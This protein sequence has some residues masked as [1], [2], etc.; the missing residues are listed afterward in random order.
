MPD[1][2][3]LER[4]PSLY[5][6]G[7]LPYSTQHDDHSTDLV[8]WPGLPRM[9]SGELWLTAVASAEPASAPFEYGAL[10][11]ANVIIYDRALAPVV[12]KFLPLGGYAEPAAASEDGVDATSARCVRFA[13]DGWSVV[14]LVQP[15]SEF[16]R[17]SELALSL[18][19]PADLRVPVFGNLGGGVYE[20][21]EIRLEEI[22]YFHRSS[23]LTVICN[24]IG[25][26][27]EPH[28][29][30]ASTNGLAG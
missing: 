16:R 18:R 4:V 30:I 25:G 26:E 6:P 29:P 12:A 15:G 8:T 2:S 11:T 7:R 13:R 10:T 27:H 17:L 9:R 19:M 24:A 1:A 3:I 20:T 14:R 5:L 22:I 28:L 23:N 21:S